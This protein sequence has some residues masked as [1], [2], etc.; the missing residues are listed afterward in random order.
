MMGSL[1]DLSAD[2]ARPEPPAQP[3]DPPPLPSALELMARSV[4]S[5]PFGPLWLGNLVFATAR[6]LLA[7]KRALDEVTPEG[8]E[9]P[10]LFGGGPMTVFNRAI[11]TRRTV[12]YG[13]APLEDVKRIKR[14][15]GVTVNDV[16]LAAAAL[17][18]RRYLQAEAE[19]PDQPLLSLVPVSTKSEAEKED[20]S[21]KVSSLIIKLPT[22]LA[23]P[24]EMLDFVHRETA[25][26]KVVFS[27]V[28]DDIM[29]EW[30]KLLPP[31][32]IAALAQIFAEW[33]LA[34]DMTSPIA[35][36]VVSNMMGPPVPLFFG[37][38]RVE[39]VFPMGP[40]AHGLG[41]NL[42]V[43]S[44]MGRLDIGVLAC[45]HTVADVWAITEGFSHAVGELKIAAEKLG[46]AG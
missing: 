3:F 19:L 33:K 29:P 15:F 4:G 8:E 36:V 38:A 37:G 20:F 7:R 14:A 22:H 12:A 28:E 39:A 32:A 18:L 41:L 40:V 16:V 1:M 43:L 11:T 34:D 21:N 9:A 10:P 13:S 6:G 17:S 45:P 44:N 24:A 35:N 26:A 46:Q 5:N 2:A 30:L 31:P 23:S 27:A 42:T 25:N